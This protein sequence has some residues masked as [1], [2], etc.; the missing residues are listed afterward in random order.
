M[1]DLGSLG[2]TLG[3]AS[4]LNDSGEVAGQSD[5][6]GDQSAHPFLWNGK[7]MLDLGTLG[8]DNGAAGWVSESGDVAGTADVAGSQAHHGFL[9]KKGIMSDLAPVDGAPCSNALFVG[10]SG[11]AVGNATDCDGTELDAMLWQHGKAY[12][13]NDLIAPSQ[14]DLITAEYANRR[15]EI[16]TRALLPNGDNRVVLLVPAA[17]AA[18]EGLHARGESLAALTASVARTR[19]RAP[20]PPAGARRGRRSHLFTTE[21]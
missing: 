4:W 20:Q 3:F 15:G 8:G 9:W 16:L 6:P 11:E 10:A 1:R 5:L 19:G 13:L 14:L 7:R 2:G 12:N 17:L 21:R 18:S